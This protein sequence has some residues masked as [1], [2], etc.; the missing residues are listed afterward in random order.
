[1]HRTLMPSPCRSSNRKTAL[2]VA[3]RLNSPLG[4]IC[5]I[6]FAG[7][8]AVELLATSAPA[9][10]LRHIPPCLRTRAPTVSGS[11]PDFA[12]LMC[13]DYSGGQ[14]HGL[15]RFLRATGRRC[16]SVDTE[17]GQEQQASDAKDV[18]G[19][20]ALPFLGSVAFLWGL[21]TGTPLQEML[22]R[23]RAEHGPVF[24][25]QTGPVRQVWVGDTQ[26]LHHIYERPEC[27]GRPVSFKDP[28]GDFLFL[29]REPTQAEPIKKRQR[30]WLED[31]MKPDSL[32][33][34][35]E[36]AM[37]QLWP[38]L[39]AVADPARTPSV[40]GAPWPDSE[41]R[42]A[43]YAAVTR[44]FLGDQGLMSNEELE[45]FMEATREYSEM[46][47]KS[48]GGG[49]GGEQLPPG[50]ARIRK[51]LEAALG[52]A[53]R[54]HE[55]EALPLMV[56]ASIGGSEIFPNLLHWIILTLAQDQSMQD[57]AARAAAAGDKQGLM[58]VMYC[59]L[60]RTAYSVA[61]GPPR[62]ILR[63][64]V[65]DGLRLPEGALLFALHPAVVDEALGRVPSEKD[66]VDFSDYAFG[67][68]PRACLG[69]SLAEAVLPAVLGS[70]L[71][72]YRVAG[73]GPGKVQ[74]VVKGQLIRPDNPPD[75]I[76]ERREG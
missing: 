1:L 38:V 5:F 33:A 49:G 75:I 70:L 36:D 9:W 30:Q 28:F 4:V 7:L 76:W 37:P 44:A 40:L 55:Q 34:A 47:V 2:T 69:Q 73:L 41:V 12:S 56:A 39:D 67:V 16:G 35:V 52:R 43:L 15:A 31:N 53:G 3:M 50:S 8:V 14:G 18:P 10:L 64:V 21:L 19:P 65:V 59:V 17:A 23:F 6:V 51:V 13:N 62:K 61:L 72:R 20:W 29:T 71:R 45:E 68:G 26:A 27:S 63:D 22:A 74:G 24:M 25:L 66:G 57:Q 58:H 48:K 46:R 54:S 60:R 11:G 32:R 42:S